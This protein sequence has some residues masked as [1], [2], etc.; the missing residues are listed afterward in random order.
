MSCEGGKTELVLQV[1]EVFQ[2]ISAGFIRIYMHS[3]IRFNSE[4]TATMVLVF[5]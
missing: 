1:M 2:V 3:S 4:G 5:A